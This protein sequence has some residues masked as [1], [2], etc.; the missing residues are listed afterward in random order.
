MA[1]HVAKKL[2]ISESK[3]ESESEN[4]D[5][6]KVGDNL[7]YIKSSQGGGDLKI[8]NEDN[9]KQRNEGEQES[10]NK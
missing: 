1:A 9:S 3:G 7:S 6:V 5:G 2:K 4:S 8:R 10:R